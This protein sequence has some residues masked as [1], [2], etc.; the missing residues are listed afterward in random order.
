MSFI[1]MR[2]ATDDNRYFAVAEF[3]TANTRATE[4]V[5]D[6]EPNGDLLTAREVSAILDY[7]LAVSVMRGA[8]DAEIDDVFARINTYGHRLSDQER[9]QAGVQGEFS[10]LVRELSCQLRG[11]A[12]STIVGIQDMP[13]I[14]ID[15]PRS[16]RGYGVSANDVFWV[17]HGILR[18]T[19]L[20]DSMDE[21]CVA[22]VAASIVGGSI[23]PRSKE[24]LDGIYEEGR[25]RLIESRRRF[26]PM[27]SRN[28]PLNLS[29]SSTK[30]AKSGVATTAGSSEIY[31]SRAEPRTRFIRCLPC[32]SLRFTR[33][34]SQR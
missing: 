29:T 15:L 11:D 34:S 24:A 30:S 17:A 23:V 5:F 31:S 4:G 18:S 27:E 21:Q 25:R 20:R 3:P 12:S 22:D 26:L 32:S 28:Y 33:Y 8:S 19:D 13:S 14:S 2:F 1:E 9:R 6:L 10:N 16:R 7:S